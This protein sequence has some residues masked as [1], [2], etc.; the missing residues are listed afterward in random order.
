M[1]ISKATHEIVFTQFIY[2]VVCAEIENASTEDV[3]QILDYVGEEMS[4]Q[5]LPSTPG[6]QYLAVV[7]AIKKLRKELEEV[8]D[9]Q[10]TNYLAGVVVVSEGD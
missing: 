3:V 2:S 1:D 9:Q 6:A 4:G 10:L 5:P 8:Y 7:N